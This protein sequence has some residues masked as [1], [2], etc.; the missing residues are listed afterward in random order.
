MRDFLRLQGDRRAADII[1]S[2]VFSL[3]SEKGF[4]NLR[5]DPEKKEAFGLLCDLFFPCLNCRKE[6]D[7][8]KREKRISE[9]ITVSDEAFIYLVLENNFDYWKRYASEL[10]GGREISRDRTRTWDV[11]PKWTVSPKQRGKGASQCEW[12]REGIKRFIELGEMV[13]KD[14][15]H[16]DL[17]EEMLIRW[18]SE[19]K[20]SNRKKR[21]RTENDSEKIEIPIYKF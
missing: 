3:I 17:E 11:Q 2:S 1:G 8:K 20:E 5:S 14:R 12:R 21:K 19:G 6:F 13:V 7:D 15:E 16:T 10:N 4:D 18:K 9:F